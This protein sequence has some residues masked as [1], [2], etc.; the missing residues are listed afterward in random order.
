MKERTFRHRPSI[1]E[2]EQTPL[3]YCGKNNDRKETSTVYFDDEKYLPTY[4]F[5]KG[6]NKNFPN[7]S[8]H[9]LNIIDTKGKLLYHDHSSDFHSLEFKEFSSSSNS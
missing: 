7:I 5:E 4:E 9:F 2:G 8:Y 1:T 6:S 3:V